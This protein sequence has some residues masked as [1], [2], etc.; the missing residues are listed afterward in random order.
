MVGSETYNI[1]P[2]TRAYTQT[3]QP[4]IVDVYTIVANTEERNYVTRIHKCISGRITMLKRNLLKQ[5]TSAATENA[6]FNVVIDI[7]ARRKIRNDRR[8]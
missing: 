2:A 4:T 1:S 5:H 8:R 3:V 7:V 6:N